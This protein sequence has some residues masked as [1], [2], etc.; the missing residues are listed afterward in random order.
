MTT[1]AKESKVKQHREPYI[2]QREAVGDG[3]S[4]QTSTTL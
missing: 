1:A 4:D 3:W 2:L